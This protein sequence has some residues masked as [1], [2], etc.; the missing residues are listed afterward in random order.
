MCSGFEF[1]QRSGARRA[2]GEI[3]FLQERRDTSASGG[4]ARET[5]QQDVNSSQFRKHVNVAGRDSRLT[6][7]DRWRRVA[8]SLTPR[9]QPGDHKLDCD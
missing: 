8:I 6:P 5:A 7:F 3:L 9:L 1:L 2:T 4:T